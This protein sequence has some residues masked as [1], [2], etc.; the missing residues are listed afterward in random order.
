VRARA[1]KARLRSWEANGVGI[2]RR[3]LWAVEGRQH[4]EARPRRRPT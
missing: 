4:D 2:G 1:S 3:H